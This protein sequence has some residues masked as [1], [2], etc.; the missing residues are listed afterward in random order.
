MNNTEDKR[1]FFIV[2][3]SRSGTTMMMRILNQ[4]STIHTINEPHFFETMWAPKDKDILIDDAAANHLLQRLITVQRDGFFA[5]IDEDKY[6][7]DIDSILAT[8]PKHNRT[9]LVIY[10]AY[11]H[12]EAKANGKQIP[13]E[14]TPQNVFYLNE[15]LT[16]FPNGKIINMV[17]DPRSV[18]LSQKRKWKR[19]FLGGT[20]LTYREMLRLMINYH[21][22][23][24]G[25]LWNSSLAAAY[26]YRKHPRILH[27]KFEGLLESP[28]ETVEEISSFL[29]VDYEDEMLRIPYAG[30]SLEADQDDVKGIR[31]ARADS[32][33][34]KLSPSEIFICQLICKKYMKLWGYKPV[35]VFPNPLRVLWNFVIFPFKLIMAFFVNIGRMRSIIDTLQRR[36]ANS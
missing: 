20:F 7:E 12:F 19:K 2:G 5:K 13:C 1:A 27:L 25:R 29:D 24:I 14:K 6:T 30:S 3:N 21:P 22:L 11:L 34:G 26:K 15:M 4:H 31:T 35:K 36:F 33:K 10:E 16:H 8:I 28:K 32:W 23:T 9:R 18:L 17:R